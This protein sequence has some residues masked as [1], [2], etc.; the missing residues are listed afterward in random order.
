MA[1]RPPYAYHAMG[2]RH[3]AAA[4]HS[5]AAQVALQVLEAGG[6]AVDAGVAGGLALNVVH[7]EY[8]HFA[9][10]APIIVRTA[11]GETMTIDGLG[12]WPRAADPEWFRRNHGGRIPPGVHRSV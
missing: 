5:V 1:D 8:T 2:T 9:G 12:A 11:A 7:C 4:A 3:M 6:N 10:V